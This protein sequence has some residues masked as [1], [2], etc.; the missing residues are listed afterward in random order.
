LGSPVWR[1]VDTQ[2]RD[3]AA[4]RDEVALGAVVGHRA[5]PVLRELPARSAQASSS[6][7]SEMNVSRASWSRRA[8]MPTFVQ[9]RVCEWSDGHSHARLRRHRSHERAR[10]VFE[11]TETLGVERSAAADLPTFPRKSTRP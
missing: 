1:Q 8:T 7:A 6:L 3:G 2:A 11:M 4:L 5:F 10:I 9:P